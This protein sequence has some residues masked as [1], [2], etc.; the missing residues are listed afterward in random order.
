MLDAARGKN[1]LEE[2][3]LMDESYLRN[4]RARLDPAYHASPSLPMATNGTE[5]NLF[6]PSTRG[7]RA[8]LSQTESKSLSV[9]QLERS[10]DSHLTGKV[11]ETLAEVIVEGS[12]PSMSGG[13]E[14]KKERRRVRRTRKRIES[15]QQ[16]ST[17]GEVKEAIKGHQPSTAS[18][19]TLNNHG[20]T[21]Q[22][23]G[24]LNLSISNLEGY[25]EYTIFHV[26]L[27]DGL[28]NQ[29]V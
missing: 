7:S 6:P 27:S 23:P 21:R 16:E 12:I 26:S 25:P 9:E 11:E 5:S 22:L 14:R 10:P 17:S 2:T 13:E 24:E 18:G 19:D 20:S 29:S 3:S 1:A 4:L 8:S 28:T 15:V